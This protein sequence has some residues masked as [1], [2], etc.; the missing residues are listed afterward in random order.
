MVMLLRWLGSLL[1]LAATPAL[2]HHSYADYQRAERY[3]LRG[4]IA[5]IHWANPHILFTVHT[6]AGDMRVEW[7]TVTGADKTSVSK[8]QF[9][10]G[11]EVVV[12]GSRNQNPDIHIMTLVKELL[13]PRKSFH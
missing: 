6:E 4:S 2:A 11:D 13:I 7:I 10:V 5:E 8:S 3:E 1:L 12:I 9:A